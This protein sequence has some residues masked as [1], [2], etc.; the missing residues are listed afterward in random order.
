[1]S[2]ASTLPTEIINHIL[3][4]R[5]FHPCARLIKEDEA[6]ECIVKKTLTW[7]ITKGRCDREG[8]SYEYVFVNEHNRFSSFSY[9][10]IVEEETPVYGIFVGSNTD[11]D[12]GEILK[13]FR[14]EGVK[15]YTSIKSNSV[16]SIIYSKLLGEKVLEYVGIYD[17][18]KNEVVFSKNYDF[19]NNKLL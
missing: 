8:I 19:K 7:K 17:F 13:S 12:S 2:V 14:Y 6:H 9:E 10:P 3:S 5:P 11:D 1:M 16:Y 18:I 15:L 4:Y